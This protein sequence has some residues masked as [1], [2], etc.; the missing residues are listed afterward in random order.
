MESRLQQIMAYLDQ[1]NISRQF[2]SP[3]E[4]IENIQMIPQPENLRKNLFPHQLS[5]VFKMEKLEHDKCICVNGYKKETLM[6]IN[7]EMTG[8]GKTMSMIALLARN[9]MEWNLDNDFIFEYVNCEA[10]G[11]IKIKHISTFKKLPTNLILIS[12]SILKQW[13]QE[14]TFS[15]LKVGLVK[16]SKIAGSATMSDIFSPSCI[17]I[18]SSAI[19]LLLSFKPSLA[20]PVQP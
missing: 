4:S 20:L 8:Y 7:S 11:R 15:D 3:P 6:G 1:G 2:E 19:S 16:T 14:L 9:K 18:V 13:Q 10:G 5:L 12:Q 17:F